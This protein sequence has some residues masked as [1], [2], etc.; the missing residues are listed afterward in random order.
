[1]Q[2]VLIALCL[3]LAAYLPSQIGITAAM[4]NCD[5]FEA[6]LKSPFVP[7]VP[8]WMEYRARSKLGCPFR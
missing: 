6:A 7:G 1:M 3:C 4:G 5:F 8:K 2:V